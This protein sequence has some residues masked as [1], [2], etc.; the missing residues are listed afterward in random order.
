MNEVNDTPAQ[1]NGEPAAPSGGGA[2][3]PPRGG[4]GVQQL[5]AEEFDVVASMG[6][7]RGLIESIAPGLVFVVVFVVSRDL[8]WSLVTSITVAVGSA[9][10]RLI[11][12]QTLTPVLSGLIGVGVGAI[13]AWRTGQAEDYFVWGLY[14]NGAMALATLGSILLRRPL[15]GLVVANLLGHGSGWRSDVRARRLYTIATALWLGA[16]LARLAVQ[17][18][19]YLNASVGWLGTARLVMGVPLWALVLYVTW[20][21][22]Q[23]MVRAG[24]KTPSVTS[25][26]D[27]GNEE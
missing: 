19:L 25:E 26:N 24:R 23:P 13:W 1:S 2:E 11:A 14:V 5:G 8:T 3:Q 27:S 22:V 15:V 17:L 4:R 10:W 6:G 12:R 20:L 7:V 21:L 18:P 16:F 9:L